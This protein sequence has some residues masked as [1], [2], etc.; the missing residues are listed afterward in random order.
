MNSVTIDGRLGKDPEVRQTNGGKTV[1]NFTIANQRNK[2]ETDWF[3][4]VAWDRTAEFISQ[5]FRKGDGINIEGRLQQERWQNNEGENRS[6]VVISVGKAG[7]PLGKNG[8]SQ[9]GN[10]QGNAPQQRQAR[11]AGTGY[12][13]GETAG[14]PPA[15]E[16]LGLDSIPFAP[17]KV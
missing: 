16:A 11:P 5:Y 7:F 4:C 12:R 6:K 2:E 10:G 3:D 8:G 14:F 1:V 15:D 17:S 13:G 9:P